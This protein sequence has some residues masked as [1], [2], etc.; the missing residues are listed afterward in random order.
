MWLSL[1]RK[2]NKYKTY[3]SSIEDIPKIA[4]ID[5]R[6]IQLDTLTPQVAEQIDEL[7]RFWNKY[8]EDM[9]ISFGDRQPIKIFINSIGGSLDAAITIMNSIRL[10]KTPVYTFNIGN[11][12]K[13]SFL[14]YLAGSK[15]F[16]YPE[17]MFMYSDAI[18]PTLP[19][20]EENE[21]TFYSQRA[22]T[23]YL[24]QNLKT[25]FLEKVSITEAQYDKHCKNEWWFSAE[26]A[27]KIH[28]A[29]EISRTHFYFTPKKN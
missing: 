17:A 8:D 22:A 27:F 13:E 20:E 15:R 23:A 3:I 25:F 9:L 21:S 12:Y 16:T 10:S 19:E 18:L 5:N 26:D 11:V 28:I 29:N 14:V 24:A 6:E 1:I 4:K 2:I 7:I